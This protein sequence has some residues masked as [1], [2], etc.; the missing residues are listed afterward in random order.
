MRRSRYR[1]KIE[2]ACCLVL[3]LVLPT[4]DAAQ[5]P[6]QQ[7]NGGQAAPAATS[8]QSRTQDPVGQAPKPV[9]ATS[10]PEVN[11]PDNPEPALSQPAGQSGQS[12]GTQT[13]S[14]PP[15]QESVQKPVGTAAAPY[16]KATG[17]AA[18]RPAGAVIAPAKQ[19]RVRSILIRV[20]I[21]VGAAVAVGTVVAL[22]H[23]SPSRSN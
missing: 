8:A 16:E 5:A 12:S 23:G 14:G 22:S 13:E 19:R 6:S 9:A 17:V 3:L 11:Y 20:G 15:Q 2:I 7:A 18:S 21:V 10:Q 1:L 4:V